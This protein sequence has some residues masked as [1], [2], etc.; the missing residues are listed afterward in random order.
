MFIYVFLYGLQRDA[1]IF[2]E[3]SREKI[4][5]ERLLECFIECVGGVMY[6]NKKIHRINTGERVVINQTEQKNNSV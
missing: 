2:W 6:L 4:S 3:R 1:K 5:Q